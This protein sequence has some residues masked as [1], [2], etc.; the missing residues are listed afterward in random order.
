MKKLMLLFQKDA[1]CTV[2]LLLAVV[3][4]FFVAPGK[5]YITY[6]DFRVLAIL[7]CLMTVVG[8]TKKLGV[9]NQ[10]SF[11][12][13]KRS[14]NRRT[15]SFFLVMLCFFSSMLITNDVALI[16]FVPFAITVLGTKRNKELIFVIVMQTIAANL[17]SMMTPVGNPQNLYLYSYYDFSAK[18]FFLLMLPTV[19]F[20]FLLIA[21]CMI[22]VKKGTLEPV[23]QEQNLS[24]G[25]KKEYLLTGLAFLLCLFSVFRFLPWQALLCL[26]LFWIFLFDR[27]LLF[28]VDYHLLL[29]FVGFFIFVGNL[30]RMEFFHQLLAQFITGR[31][32][33][34]AVLTSQVFSNVPTAVLLSGFTAE[35]KALLL[36][37]NVGGLGSLIASMASLI[38][39]KLYQ[40][41]SLADMKTYFCVFT[42]FNVLFLFLLFPFASFCI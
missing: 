36:G 7:F 26:I 12:V 3:S 15:L 27:R 19:V 41:T 37:T 25:S 35:G 28:S 8:K 6:I 34:C 1:V 9:F 22:F 24:H 21:A 16:T 38:S 11:M 40:N 33:L 13:A 2:S 14:Q 29:T 18:D 42:L 30:G 5:E 10:L 17:G 31:E 39:W 4:A 23:L 32:Y 20:S